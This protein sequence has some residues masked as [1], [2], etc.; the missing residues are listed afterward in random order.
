MIFTSCIPRARRGTRQTGLVEVFL[1]INLRLIL[2]KLSSI[3]TTNNITRQVFH[4]IIY[5]KDFVLA[6]VVALPP[7]MLKVPSQCAYERH[8]PPENIQNRWHSEE[9]MPFISVLAIWGTWRAHFDDE[10]LRF[11]VWRR[12]DFFAESAFCKIYILCSGPPACSHVYA[13]VSHLRSYRRFARKLI[14]FIWY[15]SYLLKI[16]VLDK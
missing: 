16:V 15:L 5:F 8:S 7:Y 2:L 9:W 1:T 14:K 13:S 4:K 10:S 6:I 11:I 12:L 3:R